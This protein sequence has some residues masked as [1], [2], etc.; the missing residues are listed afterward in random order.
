[1]LTGASIA[2]GLTK[3][4]WNA[5]SISIE[6]L[7]MRIVKITEEGDDLLAKREALLK[8]RVIRLFLEK[9]NGAA[10]P[11]D[12][13][14]QNVL[15]DMGVPKDKTADVLKMIVDGANSVGF[16]QGIKDKKYVDL[17]GTAAPAASAEEQL[18]EGSLALRSDA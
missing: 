18:E 5:T 15:M 14:A 12:L 4:G 8:P 16:I 7:G 9:Y 6:P 3:G 13:I 1:M 11:K 17:M 10:I 2:Y